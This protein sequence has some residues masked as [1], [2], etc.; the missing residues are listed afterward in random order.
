MISE[1][2]RQDVLR[3]LHDVIL[4]PNRMETRLRVECPL[5]YMD[6]DV[7][8]DGCVTYYDVERLIELIDRGTCHDV[9]K[10][11]TA[12]KCSECGRDYYADA[13]YLYCVE[14]EYDRPLVF[15]YCPFCGRRVVHGDD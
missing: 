3:D 10:P 5:V 13:D 6:I 2:E 1:Q 11:D 15:E 7:D 12:F 9:S 4:R 8:E 14:W